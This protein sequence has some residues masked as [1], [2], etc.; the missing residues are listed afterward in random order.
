[1]SKSQGENFTTKKG[2]M[3]RSDTPD[4]YLCQYCHYYADQ[5][6]AKTWQI[7]I[8]YSF[9]VNVCSKIQ[10]F[11]YQLHSVRAGCWLNNPR[12]HVTLHK[13]NP[14]EFHTVMYT[15]FKSVKKRVPI[16]Y[17]I[18]SDTRNSSQI[19]ATLLILRTSYAQVIM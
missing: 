2:G 18:S 6:S 16:S 13:N 7:N 15:D 10:C 8:K 14:N 19:S 3:H 12:S 17:L 5:L 11:H 4:Q 9:S 1:M